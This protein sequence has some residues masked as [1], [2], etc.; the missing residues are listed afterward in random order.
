LLRGGRKKQCCQRQQSAG[1]RA[2]L[3]GDY[4]NPILQ[5]WAQEVVKKFGEISLAGKGYPT[6]C[7][8][9]QNATEQARRPMERNPRLR[10]PSRAW[11]T[12]SNTSR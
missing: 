5:P 10:Y 11:S 6:P 2:Q 8:K 12:A 4:T 9:S 1:N 7:A 3:V